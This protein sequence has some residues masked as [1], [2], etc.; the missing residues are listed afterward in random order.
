MGLSPGTAQFMREH[1]H[2]AV[3]LADEGLHRLPDA[4]IAQKAIHEGRAIVTFDLDFSRL[5]AL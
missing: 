2:D 1:G 4:K 5:L 3:H